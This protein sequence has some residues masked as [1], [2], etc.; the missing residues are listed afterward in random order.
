MHIR[1]ELILEQVLKSNFPDPRTSRI[2]G[3]KSPVMFAQRGC[4]RLQ[5]SHGGDSMK[6]LMP[7]IS[8]LLVTCQWREERAKRGGGTPEKRVNL[9][10]SGS[11]AKL[12]LRLL[13]TAAATTTLLSRTVVDSE[14]CSGSQKDI[15][16]AMVSRCTKR[17][18]RLW[19]T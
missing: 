12:H 7:M 17:A 18:L 6:R 16:F 11:S 2:V 15:C 4:S 19:L 9:E 3:K 10:F 1:P 8:V 13:S 14:Y 5:R